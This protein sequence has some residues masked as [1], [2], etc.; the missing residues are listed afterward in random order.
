M[1]N[2]KLTTL[3]NTFGTSLISVAGEV[4]V[5]VELIK[6]QI[7]KGVNVE[8]VCCASLI[9]IVGEGVQGTVV[10]MLDNGGFAC[11]VTS[12]SGG[13]IQPNMDDPIAMSVVGELSNMI[14]GRALTQAS[15]PGIDVTPPQL[16]SGASIKTVPSQSS[17]IINFTLPF[18]VTPRGRVY[19]VLS[20]NT[21]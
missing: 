1:S 21:I 8:N 2:Q 3:V 14:S 15:L 9:G 6:T 13:M 4:G 11:T 5:E 12:M 16:I 10:I 20:F 18:Q 19:L 17:D 7:T